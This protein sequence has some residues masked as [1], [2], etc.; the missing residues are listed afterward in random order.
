[1]LPAVAALS[2]A[3]LWAMP[4]AASAPSATGAATDAYLSAVHTYAQA[5]LANDPA[6]IAAV[7]SAAQTIRSECAGVLTGAPTEGSSESSARSFGETI[8]EEEQLNDLEDELAMAV[9]AAAREPNRQALL[10][11]IAAARS[12]TWDNPKLSDALNAELA[13]IEQ[14][15]SAPAP[16]VCAD[17]EQ[18]VASGY[19]TPSASTRQLIAEREQASQRARSHLTE[20]LSSLLRPYEGPAAKTLIASTEALEKQSSKA[21]AAG[22]GTVYEQLTEELGVVHQRTSTLGHP[23][24]GV[25]VIGKGTTVAGGKYEVLVEPPEAAPGRG[26]RERCAPAHPVKAQIVTGGGVG[27]SGCFSRSEGAQRPLVS[28]SGGLLT[29]EAR[30][31]PAARTVRLQLSNGR[32]ITS[33]V[34]VVPPA[35]GGPFGFYYQVVRGPDPAPVAVT[36]FDAAGRAIRRFKL[37]RY[38]GCVEHPVKFLPGGIRILARGRVPGGPEF[39]VKGEAFRFLGRTRFALQVDIVNGGGGGESLDGHDPGVFVS[40]LFTSCQPRPYAIVYGLLKA[41]GDTVLARVNGALEPLRKVTIPARLHAGGVLV[42][43][44][45]DTVPSE[46]I[47]RAPNGSTV[48]SETRARVGREAVERC[49][50]EHEASS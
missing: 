21:L 10:A 42:Y 17:M 37:H 9:D 19:R 48:V 24:P 8:R 36:E 11:F 44:A 33:P 29:I 18:W 31:L 50:G 20:S 14:H 41:R 39:A 3:F 1:M 5:A 7:D 26:E 30:T 38:V 28:C 35:L 16:P 46:L 45:A 32:E 23:A 47:V 6:T 15:D 40:G 34:A 4:A 13:E 25:V 12:I 27:I 2:S 49:E 43:L 22:T